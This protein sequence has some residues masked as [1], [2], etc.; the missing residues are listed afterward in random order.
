MSNKY[1]CYPW[2]VGNIC[3][4]CGVTRVNRNSTCLVSSKY[5]PHIVYCSIV[6]HPVNPCDEFTELK[7]AVCVRSLEEHAQRTARQTSGTD[8]RSTDTVPVTAS[9]ETDLWC[10][11][12]HHSQ[13]EERC[14]AE[15]RHHR[16]SDKLVRYTTWLGIKSMVPFDDNTGISSET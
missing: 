4:Q 3:R 14:W 7:T 6:E 1:E 5:T 10:W 16:C 11:E 9:E 12:C 2:W 8:K 15:G 13:S